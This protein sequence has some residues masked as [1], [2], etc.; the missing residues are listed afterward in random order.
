VSSQCLPKLVLILLCFFL[1]GC[2]SQG[3]QSMLAPQGPEA[4]RILGLFWSLVIG[5]AAIIT[6]VV[7][8]LAAALSAS[9]LR[10]RLAGETAVIAGGLVLPV[11][12]LTIL[13][14]FDFL[15]TRANSA[16][17]AEAQFRVSI[18]GEQWWWRIA[19]VM[20][21]GQRVQTANEL[22]IPVGVP[23]ALELTSADVIHSFW[24]PKLAGKLDMI[25][26]RKTLLHLEASEPGLSRGQCAEYCGGPHAYMSFHVMAREV[27]AFQA[28][29]SQQAGPAI[30]P[31]GPIERRGSEL[32]LAA[33][34]AGCHTIRGTSAHG[35]IGPDL[36]HVGSR[37]FLAAATLPNDA[38]AF[39]RWI[40]DNQHIKPE[41]R[42]PP[43]RQ[44]SEAELA[45]LSAYLASLK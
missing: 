26:G 11:A 34:C 45:A 9:S 43:F 23:I 14:V 5:G 12:V 21:D 18:V 35:I 40:V 15:L 1:A 7:V 33:G 6:L 31:S 2:E 36:T 17:P 41:N 20:A 27:A 4:K 24:V 8:L 28:W 3:M 10:Q 37:Q 16:P 38:P 22:H 32:F 44:F 29:L 42:M 19:Y 39:A 13:L 30:P 25:P